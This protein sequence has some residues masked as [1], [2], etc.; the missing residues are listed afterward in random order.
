MFLRGCSHE[1]ITADRILNISIVL[2]SFLCPVVIL[3]S[4]CA[5]QAPR[6]P[7]V[8]FLSLEFASSRDLYKCSHQYVLFCCSTFTWH[9]YFEIHLC[10]VY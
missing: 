1:T 2:K 10:C 5:T 7:P 4:H 6:Q 9:N 8:H 3:S